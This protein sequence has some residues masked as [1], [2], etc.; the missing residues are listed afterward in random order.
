MEHLYPH[1]A[2]RANRWLEIAIEETRLL[3]LRHRWELLAI[4]V[5]SMLLMMVPLHLGIR[6]VGRSIGLSTLLSLLIFIF[7]LL[8]CY[9]GVAIWWDQPPR[10]RSHLWTLP[11]GR[12]ANHLHRVL[13]GAVL[14]LVV[15]NLAWIIGLGFQVDFV[16]HTGRFAVRSFPYSLSPAALAG[17]L[18]FY[19]LGAGVALIAERP[20]R[21]LFVWLPIGVS[22]LMLI[23]P[24]V[25]LAKVADVVFLAVFGL[26]GAVPGFTVGPG[27]RSM[28]LIDTYGPTG[29]FLWL[30]AMLAFVL[31]AA[32]YHQER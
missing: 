15:F 11:M 29:P 3:V 9:W 28:P 6:G 2:A 7:P 21:I 32:R 12:V 19:L 25:G 24:P 1:P 20:V 16:R 4:F 26:Y 23:L 27:G 17:L 13:I 22:G 30:A 8:A 14:L 10:Q 31:V 18:N 5:I